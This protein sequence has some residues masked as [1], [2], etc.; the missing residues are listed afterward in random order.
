MKFALKNLIRPNILALKPYSSARDEFKGDDDLPFQHGGNLF[1][2]ANENPFNNHNRYPDPYQRELKTA[3][4]ERNNI[5][6][7]RIFIGN[8]SDEVI[9]IA[10]RVFCNPGKDKILTFIPTYGMYKVSAAINDVEILQQPLTEDFQ[11]DRTALLEVIDDKSL[12]IIFLCSPNNPTGNTLNAEDI[13][14]I[15]RNFSGIVFLDEAYIDFADTP[16]WLARLEEFPNLIISQTFSKAQGKA[17]IRVG[18][19]YMSPEILHFY[20]KVKPPYN[21]SALN[22]EAAVRQLEDYDTFTLNVYMILQQRKRMEKDLQA[23]DFVKKIY[24]SQANFLLVEVSDADALYDF[25]ISKNI[26]VRNRSKEVK[27]TLRFTIGAAHENDEV[28]QALQAYTAAKA[29]V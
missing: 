2:D 22:Q 19:G 5:S 26:I 1:L 17:A 14:F 7:D 4:S 28:L 8:G 18:V 9:D 11:I 29:L 21:V 3:L 12:K 6:A 16:S 23:F 10:L 15:C 20:N 25:L 24:P 27:N 13:E